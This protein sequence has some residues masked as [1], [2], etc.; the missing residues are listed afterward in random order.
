[1]AQV[2]T[3]QIRNTFL[4]YYKDF[5]DQYYLETERNYKENTSTQARE[6]LS[7]ESFHQYLQKKDFQTIIDSL[8]KI[9]A[10]SN[11]SNWRDY[12]FLRYLTPDQQEELCLIIYNLLYEDSK[13]I[14]NRIDEVATFLQ[15]QE[16]V[17]KSNSWNFTTFLLFT[18]HPD[19]H[20]FVKPSIWKAICDRLS[21]KDP[22]TRELS[23]QSY[24]KILD[25]VNDIKFK[26]KGTDLEPQDMIDLQSALYLFTE[27]DIPDERYKEAPMQKNEHQLFDIFQKNYTQNIILEG[28][29]GTGKT[30]T[31]LNL[32]KH[33]L[34]NGWE[35]MQFHIINDYSNGAWELIQFHPNYSFEDFVRGLVAEPTDNGVTF[36]AKNKIFAQMCLAAGDNPE[37]PF[38]LIIDEINR[39][40]LSK[41]LGELIFGL[42][43]REKPVSLLYGTKE[44][45]NNINTRLVVPKNL[46]IVGTMNTADRSIALVDYAIRRRFSFF[47]LQPDREVIETFP[48]YASDEVRNIALQRFDQVQEAFDETNSDYKI[49]HTYFLTGD[50]EQPGTLDSLNFKYN[51]QVIPLLEEYL[52]EGMLDY[53]QVEGLITYE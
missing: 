3:A 1:M 40:D 38:L 34:G 27:I 9:F 8:R 18:F 46:Y 14:E 35:E 39:G 16:N 48:H 19:Q 5:S 36:V 13:S 53:E 17:K 12:D 50:I 52:K 24:R 37:A 4:K 2:M 11:L 25:I 21:I 28:P 23:G 31:A 29:P 7:P 22:R 51:Y 33:L 10:M 15:K 43:Y 47:K 44:G 32:A 45:S 6:L 26:L 30:F 41:V 42:E 20:Y 49:G